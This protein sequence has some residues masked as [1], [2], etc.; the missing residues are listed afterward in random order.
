[1]ASQPDCLGTGSCEYGAKTVVETYAIVRGQAVEEFADESGRSTSRMV[2]SRQIRCPAPRTALRPPDTS[3]RPDRGVSSSSFP[4]EE[5]PGRL[6]SQ[7]LA[8]TGLMVVFCGIY[9]GSSCA[10]PITNFERLVI[11]D[12]LHRR[13]CRCRRFCLC[14]WRG[15]FG[16][17]V[18]PPGLHGWRGPGF[19]GWRGSGFLGGAALAIAGRRDDG[20]SVA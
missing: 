1:M 5:R 11:A 13:L 14:G 18:A 9:F 8:A 6:V 12:L 2:F 17:R 7:S 16:P 10:V 15:P 19:C 20:R 3:D 4:A